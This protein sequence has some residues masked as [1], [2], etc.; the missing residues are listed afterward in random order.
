VRTTLAVA[1][2]GL[3]AAGC[4][5]EDREE[6]ASDEGCIILVNG[7]KLCGDDA[8]A[9]CREFVGGASS[10]RD[11]IACRR[12]GVDVP[13]TEAER[14]AAADEAE[15]RAD[16]EAR[17]RRDDEEAVAAPYEAAIRK[18]MGSQADQLVRV[19]VMRSVEVNTDF[20]ADYGD[21]V[22]PAAGVLT[23]MCKAAQRV[24]PDRPVEI[25]GA[26]EGDLEPLKS[27]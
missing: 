20:N 9:Y 25:W 2:I 22:K 26:D 16:E 8:R 6:R 23:R 3:A 17:A 14:Q 21:K 19:R 18:A 1:L 11:A 27:C 4:G 12:I 5:G 24:D 10:S 15:V 13:A 7:N